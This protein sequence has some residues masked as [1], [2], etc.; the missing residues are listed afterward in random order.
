[1]L[2]KIMDLKNWSMSMFK[3][4]KKHYIIQQNPHIESDRYGIAAN[5]LHFHC[6]LCIVLSMYEVFIN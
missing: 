3:G 1:M 5:D 2:V 4:L 6:K